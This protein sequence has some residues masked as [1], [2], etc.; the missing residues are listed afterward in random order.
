MEN[1]VRKILMKS[2]FIF[3]NFDAK[4]QDN[5]KLISKLFEI[6]ELIMSIFD[7]ISKKI[8]IKL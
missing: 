2:S 3:K 8:E 7:I 4:C 6:N 5:L 1:L